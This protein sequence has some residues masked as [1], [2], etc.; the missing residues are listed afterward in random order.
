VNGFV[1]ECRQEWKRLRVPDPVA[2]EMAADLAADLQ[3]AEAEGVSA[4]EVLGSGAFDPRGFAASWATERGVIQPQ[5]VQGVSQPQPVQVADRPPGRWRMVVAIAVFAAI[6]VIGAALVTSRSGTSERVAVASAV[7]PLG[8]IGVIPSFGI[9]YP[10][11]AVG[12]HSRVRVQ[13][14]GAVGGRITAVPQPSF[15][16]TQPFAVQLNGPSVALRAIG[17]ILL[18]IGIGGLIL[19]TLFLRPWARTGRWSRRPTDDRLSSTGYH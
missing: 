1:E 6:T 9:P 5:P 10:P 11:G 4:E 17:L 16:G 3:E 14:R 15:G 13:P 2:N 8:R 18:L 7:G 12:P 19:S